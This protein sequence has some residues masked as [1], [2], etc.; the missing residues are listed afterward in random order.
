M[1]K[2]YEEPM[3]ADTA[4]QAAALFAAFDESAGHVEPARTSFSYAA[5]LGL[6]A[7]ALLFLV[8]L[9]PAL[10]AGTAWFL[11]WHAV[12]NVAMLSE[13]RLV[14]LYLLLYFGPLVVG[15]IF[16]FF[17]AKPLFAR[18]VHNTGSFSL[19]RADAPLLFAFIGRI[20]RL[21]NAPLPSRVD[22]NC[23]VNASA[24]FRAGLTS[25]FGNDIILTIGLP[26]TA[27]LS[28][29]EFAGVLAHEFA[30]FAQGAG[31][32][33]TY[34]IR[35][36]N[37]WFLRVVYERDAWDMQL[38]R[39]AL[40]HDWRSPVIQGARLC[41]WLTRR[42]LWLLMHLSHAI[43][44][45]MLRQME[46]A[47]DRLQCQVAGWDAFEST[48]QKLHRLD[49]ANES[50]QID[51]RESWKARRLP[52]HLPAFILHKQA[53]L[54]DETV[55]H[56]DAAQADRKT[57]WF[58]TH[59]ST[60]DRIAAARHNGEPGIFRIIAPAS[61]LF[62]DF[63]AL[64]Q[65]ATRFYYERELQLPLKEQSLVDQHQAVA[66][67]AQTDAADNAMRRYFGD[68]FSMLR[69]LLIMTYETEATG[70]GA[71]RRALVEA[72]AQMVELQGY[73]TDLLAEFAKLDRQLLMWNKAAYLLQGGFT[74]NPAEFHLT[75]SSHAAATQARSRASLRQ[76]QLETHLEAYDAAVRAR[77]CAALQL[78][79]ELVAAGHLPAERTG[80]I[81]A[82]VKVLSRFGEFHRS[83]LDM[84]ARI[85][86]LQVVLENAAHHPSP[87]RVGRFL[88]SLNNELSETAR[89]V[90]DRCRDVP[91]P[92]AHA[93]GAISIAEYSRND[94]P[95]P[96]YFEGILLDSSALVD[97]MFSLHYRVV[98]R[99]VD[100]AEEVERTLDAAP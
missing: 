85:A 89:M 40:N 48:L 23:D 36:I 16:L 29:G 3:P 60:A 59:P 49:A 19:N 53:T 96:D 77:L 2:A 54:S 39:A 67:V 41:I 57:R 69:P 84:R 55:Q 26:L 74:F 94:I 95:S 86:G 18:R 31:M 88:T 9:Y 32:R 91:Y 12:H 4:A 5:G 73:A 62:V 56:L 58:D 8:A 66:E 14:A 34:L 93:G 24:G 20:C 100:I 92:F 25:L 47:A 90:R 13:P 21:T 64:G 65:S 35:S 63:D 87:E 76:K 72:R 33:L 75:A 50:A 17:L 46:Y 15:I 44:C 68:A 61:E 79:P 42:V 78:V 71:A 83:L 38:E 80:E 37:L 99:I 97:R 10:I 28:M 30:H 52:N 11:W 27:G 7:L 82:F 70:G 81:R 45:F 1:P 6:V 51:L 43:S 22:V 98:S